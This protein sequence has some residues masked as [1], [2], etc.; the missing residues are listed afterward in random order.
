MVTEWMQTQ[1]VP[2]R[3][4]LGLVID[5]EVKGALV[6]RAARECRS[7]SSPCANILTDEMEREAA[8]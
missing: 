8:R 6:A 3:E 1:P 4:H 5:P 2:R 7:L